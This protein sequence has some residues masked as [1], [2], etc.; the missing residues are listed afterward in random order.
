MIIKKAIEKASISLKSYKARA[1][2]V[3]SITLKLRVSK[4][5]YKTMRNSNFVK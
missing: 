3:F 2:R 1:T 5:H 4:N